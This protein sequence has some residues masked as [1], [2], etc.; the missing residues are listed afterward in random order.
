METRIS[1]ASIILLFTLILTLLSSGI[2]ETLFLRL[3]AT[4][5]LVGLIHKTFSI[6]Y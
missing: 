4:G 1:I 6:V 3:G 2:I 5:K